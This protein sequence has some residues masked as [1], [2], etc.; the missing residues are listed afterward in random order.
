[1]PTDIIKRAEIQL[2]VKCLRSDDINL[3]PE[4]REVLSDPGEDEYVTLLLQTP[5]N[6]CQLQ[7]IYAILK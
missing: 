5:I 4:F 2:R 3:P 7:A 1:M 6:M